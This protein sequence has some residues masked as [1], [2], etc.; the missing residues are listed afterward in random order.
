M[1]TLVAK[2][3]CVINRNDPKMKTRATIATRKITLN[4]NVEANFNSK[5]KQEKAPFTISHVMDSS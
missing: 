4:Q 5:T 2:R 1:Q 3:M